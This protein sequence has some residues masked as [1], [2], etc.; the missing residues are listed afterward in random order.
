MEDSVLSVDWSAVDAW[1]FAGVSYNGTFFL[2]TVPSKTK[3]S[4]LIWMIELLNR[5]F[6][7]CYGINLNTIIKFIFKH[8][9][10]S[11]FADSLLGAP[12]SN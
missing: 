9:P 7:V 6:F 2:N 1:T 11:S 12:L 8:I 10:E 3:Y 4:I 5:S